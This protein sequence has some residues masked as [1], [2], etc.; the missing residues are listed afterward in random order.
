M[1]LAA[2]HSGMDRADSRKWPPDAQPRFGHLL[3]EAWAD[4]NK[5]ENDK[6]TR[7]G[8]R[9]RVSGAGQCARMIGYRALGVEKSEP[10]TLS[11]YWRMG[12]GTMVHSLLE[13][14]M[15]KA[16]PGAE[17]EY[18]ID[19]RTHERFPVDL[20]GSGDVSLTYVAHEPQGD[21]GERKVV[22]EWKTINGFGF[23]MMV[24]ARK[25]FGGVDETGPKSNHVTQAALEGYHQDAD[26]VV[27]GYLSL[28]CL[29]QREADKLGTD[30]IGKFIA[31]FTMPREMYVPI[32]EQELARLQRIMDEFVDKGEL[33][34]RQVPGVGPHP[35]TRIVD[36]MSGKW[37]FRPT[38]DGKEVVAEA[39]EYWGC[40]Y[41][42]WQSRCAKDGPT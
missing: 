36:P 24:G 23:K 10:T 40:G 3:A 11:G 22:I 17:V 5:V 7:L 41:C 4:H 34:P 26:E 39:G 38:V 37:E 13:P 19:Y 33:P 31:E 12:L 18:V 16:F 30:D 2:D 29:S 35:K 15:E 28:E 14:V 25:G 9:L 6:P 42:D 27:I 8:T 20:S 32:A 21:V 1:P